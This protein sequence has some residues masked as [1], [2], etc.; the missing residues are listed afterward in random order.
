M[1]WMRNEMIDCPIEAIT[2]DFFEIFIF[3]IIDPALT[4]EF[5]L[6]IN[7]VANNCQNAIP[8]IAK[9]GYGTL[10][11]PIRKI[12]DS[13]NKINVPTLIIG[14]MKAHKIP[15]KDCL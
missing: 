2:N 7:P 3:I 8:N 12:P 6:A 14:I 1:S 13:F 4:K 5:E 15:K 11:S 9:I 10:I